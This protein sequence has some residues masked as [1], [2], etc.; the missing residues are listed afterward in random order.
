MSRAADVT[1][2]WADGTYRFRLPYGQLAELQER[3]GCGPQLLLQRVVDGAWKV[4]DL[5]ETIRLGLIGGGLEPVKALALVRRYVEERPLLESVTPA[6]LI[7]S[8]ALF[9]VEGEEWPGKDAPGEDRSADPSPTDGSTSPGS[10][11]APQ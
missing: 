2:D 4:D 9:G 5:R 6:R 7:L 3:T 8:A 10:T 11:E 1:F